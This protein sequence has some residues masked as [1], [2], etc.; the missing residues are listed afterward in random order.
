MLWHTHRH[1]Q[2]RYD[3]RDDTV[4]RR[5]KSGHHRAPFPSGG[6]PWAQVIR[7]IPDEA[8]EP[9][10]APTGGAQGTPG[11]GDAQAVFG[12]RLPS[13]LCSHHL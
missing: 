1:H 8:W 9:C 5:G 3:V 11:R 12:A 6:G 13:H 2:Y 4:I 10:D 7:K